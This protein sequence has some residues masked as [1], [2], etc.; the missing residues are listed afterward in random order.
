MRMGRKPSAYKS[1]ISPQGPG[2]DSPCEWISHD[3]TTFVLSV[4]GDILVDTKR[5]W[6]LRQSW[7][8][9]GPIFED[10]PRGRVCVHVFVGMSVACIV[11]V[12]DVLCNSQK[13]IQ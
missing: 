11:S 3:L 1:T 12:S 8:F 5:L 7:G 9:V 10:A 4:V 2:L 6:W 13:T